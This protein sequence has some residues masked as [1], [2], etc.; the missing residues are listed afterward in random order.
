MN[1]GNILRA[2]KTAIIHEYFTTRIP[3][4][5]STVHCATQNIALSNSVRYI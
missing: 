2:V 1:T 3:R 4:N 5:I